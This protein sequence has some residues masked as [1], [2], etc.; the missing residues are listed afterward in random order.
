ME[1]ANA[2]Q[3]NQC[4]SRDIVNRLLPSLFPNGS[5]STILSSSRFRSRVDHFFTRFFQT[6]SFE[7]CKFE[8]DQLFNELSTFRNAETEARLVVDCFEKHLKINCEGKFADSLAKE[9]LPFEQLVTAVEERL[10]IHPKEDILPPLIELLQ[11]CQ[12]L[13]NSFNQVFMNIFKQLAGIQ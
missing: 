3:S 8:L 1:L 4:S 9:L 13:V 2:R 7:G 11:G 5:S 6:L 10:A 12:D